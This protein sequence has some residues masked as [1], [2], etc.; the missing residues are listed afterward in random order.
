MNEGRK[1]RSCATELEYRYQVDGKKF[2]LIWL[3]EP[4]LVKMLETEKD[5]RIERME[6]M[7]VVDDGERMSR[8]LARRE[9]YVVIDFADLGDQESDPFFQTLN[10]AQSH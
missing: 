2:H 8:E 5:G 1:E 6:L 4:K 10:A 9:T 3:P 7:A